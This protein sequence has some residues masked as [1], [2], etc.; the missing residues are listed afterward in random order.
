MIT[1]EIIK[2][3]WANIFMPVTKFPCLTI[4]LFCK[5]RPFQSLVNSRVF[6]K[7]PMAKTGYLALTK[8][9]REKIWIGKVA[10]SCHQVTW[11]QKSVNLISKSL[12]VIVKLHHLVLRC[13][14][15]SGICPNQLFRPYLNDK[16]DSITIY[17]ISLSKKFGVNVCCSL[18]ERRV[19]TENCVSAF[20]DVGV[21][22]T[23]IFIS[24]IKLSF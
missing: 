24:S 7:K 10:K 14:I 20:A 9:G 8:K 11:V 3:F 18:V 5:K 4:L 15:S 21:V 23:E 22:N 17:C 12:N 6:S 2:L 19:K 13:T 16:W 1:I